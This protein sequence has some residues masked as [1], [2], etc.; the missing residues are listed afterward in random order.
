MIR[1]YVVRSVFV[2]TKCLAKML[3]ETDKK[4]S[5]I[6]TS[7]VRNK[8]QSYNFVSSFVLYNRA[9]TRRFQT[10]KSS[11]SFN[12]SRSVLLVDKIVLRESI[13]EHSR[14]PF[15]FESF[16]RQLFYYHREIV[17]TNADRTTVNRT[18]RARIMFYSP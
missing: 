16:C 10:N 5:R 11:S 4:K 1:S 9:S 7:V 6:G 15:V 17:S 18:V 2:Y 14:T 8:S 13:L 3:N 12:V